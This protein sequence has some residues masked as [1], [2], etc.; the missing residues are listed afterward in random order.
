MLL[1]I[2]CFTPA[3]QESAEQLVYQAF[4]WDV[5]PPRNTAG[6]VCAPHDIFMVHLCVPIK[7]RRH[8]SFIVPDANA[9]AAS[10]SSALRRCIN[11]RQGNAG[12]LDLSP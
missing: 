6:K 8:H 12:A 1:T 5:L 2:T 7:E 4:V 10:L 11:C 3:H 9:H